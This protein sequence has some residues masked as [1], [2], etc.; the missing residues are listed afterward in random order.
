MKS[1]KNIL[2]LSVLI[3]ALIWTGVNLFTHFSAAQDAKPSP[4]PTPPSFK[5]ESLPKERGEFFTSAGICDICHKQIGDSQGNDISPGATWRGTMMANAA[6]DPYW[7]A[8]MRAET[9]I[10]P[11]LAPVIEDACTRCHMPMART[12]ANLNGQTGHALDDG[13]LNAANPLHTL[14]MEGVSCTLCHQIEDQYLGEHES[15]DGGYVIN[16]DAPAGARVAYGPYQPS[17]TDSVLM[18]GSSSFVPRKGLH[19]QSSELCATC[20]TLY[21]PTVDVASGEITGEFPEQMPYFEWLNSDFATQKTCQ[22]CHMPQIE[23]AVSLSITGSPPR[24]A[25]SRHF[26]TGGNTYALMLLRHFGE[27]LG[28]TASSEQ[29]DAALQRATAQ[30]Q[31]QTAQIAITE[32]VLADDMLSLTVQVT[33]L[34]GHKLPTAYPSR[35]AWIHLLVQDAS[36]NVVFE[37]GNWDVQGAIQGNDND[38]DALAYEPHYQVI[39]SSDQVQIYEAIFADTS[40]QV[41]TTLLHGSHYLK[42]NRL[43]PAGFEKDTAPEEIAVQ[44]EAAID[45]DFNANGD[46]VRYEIS[47]ADATGPFKVTAELL[48]QSIGYRWAQKMA[49]FDAPETR[50][51]ISFYGQV[52]NLPSLISSTTIEVTR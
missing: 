51:F 2:R 45:T 11:E 15:F 50:Q 39:T 30:L 33:N 20:H 22:D 24:E 23:T 36:G 34:S 41:S 12:S 40:N 10:N 8:A 29:I 32:S 47:L 49:G 26:F 1:I 38:A 5:G 42:D 9:L 27:T 19:I 6:R 3:S 13:F 44:G 28:V 14:A 46:R 4:T 48:Y 17:E 52:P 21:T 16:A 7:Q 25:Y 18:Q 31:S 35:R 43:L 37:S